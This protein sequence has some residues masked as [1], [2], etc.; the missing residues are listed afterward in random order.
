MKKKYSIILL[1]FLLSSCNNNHPKEKHEELVSHIEWLTDTSH[2][3]G[4]YSERDTLKHDFIFR[5]V[6]KVPFFIGRIKTSCGC[7][8]TEYPN[9]PVLQGECDTIR[10]IYDGNGFRPGKYSKTIKVFTNSD[11][12]I[13][14]K[15]KGEFIP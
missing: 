15:I 6:G 10:V 9:H 14:L 11:S 5:N 8:T 4:T 3:F 2:D 1:L 7:T 12:V 13:S